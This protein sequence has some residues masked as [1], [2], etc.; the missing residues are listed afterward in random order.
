MKI[1]LIYPGYP[2]TFWSF[3]YALRFVGK[4]ASNPPVGLLTVAAM[5]PEDWDLKLVD[6]NV[7]SLRDEEIVWADLVFIS[8]MTVQRTSAKKVICKCHQLDRRVVAGGPLFTAQP[9]EFPE[10]DHLILN[11]AE[12]TLPQ[13]LHDL[14]NGCLKRVYTSP[15]W[16]DITTTP[17][18]RWDLIDFKHYAT[19]CIQYSRG[20]PFD[21]E[22]CDITVLYGHKPR[23]KPPE[24]VIN[25]LETLYNGGW[26]GGVFFVDDNFIGNKKRIKKDLLPEM[27]RWMKRRKY[28]FSFLTQ[29]S[30]NLADDEGLMNLMV[31]AGFDM[32]FVGIETPDEDSL[33][34]CGKKQ[35]TKSDLLS[36]VKKLHSWGL[37]V[38]A[39]FIVGFDSDKLDIFSRMSRFIN[40]SGI[41]A[42][43]VGLLNAPPNTRLYNR[44]IKEN[45]ILKNITG[46]NTDFSM[47]FLPKMDMQ[48][49]VEG[50]KKII[51]DIYRPEAYYK[52]VRTFLRGYRFRHKFNGGFSSTQLRGLVN[53]IYKLGIK[54]GVRKHFWKL[55]AWTLIRR[56]RL[57]PHAFTMA[58]YG[59]HFMR[60]FETLADRAP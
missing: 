21:C 43:M 51:S 54:K 12:I 48:V 25:E 17:V 49:L 52:R 50:Y 36:S 37:Q 58:I 10:A 40:D 32:V 3:S 55:M 27:I 18:P 9:Q 59:A 57:M 14:E 11:E 7:R 38:Q 60:H 46:D 22:F 35:N 41:V 15:E 6:M 42:S 28:P 33:H 39:G 19:M 23:T 4:K 20:C 44:L 30:M 29:A 56:P 31:E 34:E 5:L 24:N 16:A 45:R 1:L 26:R 47:N 13:F 53:S 2:D 8:A